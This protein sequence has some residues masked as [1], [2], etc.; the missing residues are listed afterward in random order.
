LF[1]VPPANIS[2]PKPWFIPLPLIVPLLLSNDPA[3]ETPNV[4]AR[5]AL[6]IPPA[7]F[8]ITEFAPSARIP[9]SAKKSLPPVT[10]EALRILELA[11][12]DLTPVF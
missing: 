1:T 12:E 2:T 5:V 11:A 9:W 4:T 7:R 6:I 3:A 10:V 8:E